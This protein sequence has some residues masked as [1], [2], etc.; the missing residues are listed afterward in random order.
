[1]KE[2]Y[3]KKKNNFLKKF[4]IKVCRF[5]NFE[6]IDQA[7]FY[8]PLENK[9][10][11]ESLSVLGNK[12]ITIPMG[13]I[14]IKR[15]VHN[16]DIIF[17]SC[18]SVNMLTQNKKRLFEK[19]KSEY[20]LRSLNSIVRSLNHSKEDFK[21]IKIKIT[22][23]DH[24]SSNHVIQSMNGILSN[25]YFES[26]VLKLDISKFENEIDK[27]NEQKN[28][29][30]NNQI[31]NMSNI[32][33]SILLAKKCSDLVYFVEDDYIHTID[34]FKEIT[35][36]YE[37]FSTILEKDIFLCPA[38][39]PYLYNSPEYT[40]VLLGDKK[41]WRIVNQTLCTFLTSQKLV[42]QY[43]KELTSM[44]KFEHYPF[45]KP[46]HEIY[47]KEY[48]FSPVPSL[49]MHC[50]NINSVYGLPPNFNLKKIWDEN[51]V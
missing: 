24:N 43:F 33:Q 29:V 27:I 36:T 3:L 11:D 1:M 37:K 38:D 10:G 21:N 6:I 35:S 26:E 14:K 46:L 22:V 25:N 47:K 5:F 20:T 44:C 40:R 18:S 31:S 50:T 15:P 41:H 34:S 30:S 48:C 45:E 8:L 32:H 2:S 4:F 42:N 16:L 7:S 49:A 39:Y 9:I 28:N 51:E 17:R 13:K 23:I 12:S 19:E